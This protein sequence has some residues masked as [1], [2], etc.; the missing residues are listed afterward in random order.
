MPYV[1]DPGYVVDDLHDDPQDAGVVSWSGRRYLTWDGGW[2]MC[3][4]YSFGAGR[5]MKKHMQG[6]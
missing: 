2:V 5:F 3:G 6:W 4:D 1:Y